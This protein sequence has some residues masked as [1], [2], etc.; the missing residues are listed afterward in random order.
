MVEEYNWSNLTVMEVLLS[1]HRR[2]TN[3]TTATSSSSEEEDLFGESN[4][5]AMYVVV[6]VLFL[7]Y[8]G[9]AC[10]YCCYRCRHYMKEHPPLE[11]IRKIVRR[12]DRPKEENDDNEETETE[13]I[14]DL[15]ISIEDVSAASSPGPMTVM[16]YVDYDDSAMSTPGMGYP[17]RK[18]R[19]TSGLDN[20][21]ETA[22]Q[23]MIKE[24]PDENDENDSGIQGDSVLTDASARSS[25]K[26][27]L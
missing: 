18:E 1:R 21:S 5:L 4:K 20:Y 19:N 9:C 10:I 12:V 27:I 11:K 14:N 23:T 8:G 13:S 7:V 16:S 15:P 22:N 6:P 17:V 25:K 24:E 2:S 26:S 3:T